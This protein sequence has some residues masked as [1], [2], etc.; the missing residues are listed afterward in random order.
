[1]RL[2]VNRD[3]ALFHRLQECGLR[4]RA[5]PVDLVREHDLGEDRPRSELEVIDLLVERP[6]ACDVRRQKIRGELDAAKGAVERTG[7]RLGEHGLADPGDI[8]D[9]QVPFAKQG[10]EAELDLFFFVDDRPGHV[11]HERI[12][13]T[14]DDFS[15]PHSRDY[16]FAVLVS[17]LR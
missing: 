7:Q 11:L 6:D 2:S 9:Q 8:L 12:G 4:L 15:C 10:D 14:S 17:H 16:R 13:D 5:G 3:L 1:M